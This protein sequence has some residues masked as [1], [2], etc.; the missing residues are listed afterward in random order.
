MRN[1]VKFTHLHWPFGL[2]KNLSIP[3]LTRPHGFKGCQKIPIIILQIN[4]LS[5]R[6]WL[7]GIE[8]RKVI[9]QSPL[10]FLQVHEKISYLVISS[11]LIHIGK[12]FPIFFFKTI[13]G[14]SKVRRVF[15]SPLLRIRLSVQSIS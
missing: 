11:A 7:L 8:L 4:L 10:S 2:K 15:D 13:L 1:Y 12:Y 14:L 5:Y 3:L 6:F 9:L